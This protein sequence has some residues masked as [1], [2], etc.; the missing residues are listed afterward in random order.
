MQAGVALR[1]LD[2]DPSRV[3]ASLEA[4]RTA[5]RESLDGLRAEL[6]LL[7]RR[8]GSTQAPRRPTSGLADLP[9]LVERM[10]ASGLP[11]ALDLEPGPLPEDID[12]AAYRIVQES[13]TNVLRHAGPDATARVRV[14]RGADALH[15]AVRNTGRLVAARENSGHGIEGMRERAEALGGELHARPRPSGGFA[16]EARIPWPEGVQIPGGSG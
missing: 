1:M 8:A 16:V 5:S 3:R 4:I 9:D 13:L 7:R 10:R 14:R 12:H 15:L 2:R 6:D 11:V